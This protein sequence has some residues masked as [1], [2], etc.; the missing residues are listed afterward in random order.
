MFTF[1]DIP[2][3][4]LFRFGIVG[5]LNGKNKIHQSKFKVISSSLKLPEQKAAKSRLTVKRR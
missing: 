3:P 1:L 4:S 2:L 5:D